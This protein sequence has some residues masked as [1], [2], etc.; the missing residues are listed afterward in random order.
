MTLGGLVAN[1]VRSTARML[2]FAVSGHQRTDVQCSLVNV[3]IGNEAI[4]H[5]VAVAPQLAYT[6]RSQYCTNVHM[7]EDGAGLVDGLQCR[8]VERGGWLLRSRDG[9]FV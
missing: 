2:T 7:A 1:S 4:H 6:A 9:L 8:H 3:G 5:K